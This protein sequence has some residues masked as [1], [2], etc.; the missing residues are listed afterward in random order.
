MT[1]GHRVRRRKARQVGQADEDIRCELL[2]MCYTR[3]AQKD[4]RHLLNRY[5]AKENDQREYNYRT[6][7]T[8]RCV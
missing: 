7:N 2:T 4:A 8:L 1:D 3:S 6:C 5:V